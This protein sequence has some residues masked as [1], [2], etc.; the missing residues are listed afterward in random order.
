MHFP[1]CLS[2]LVHGYVSMQLN[3]VVVVVVVTDPSLGKCA[4]THT[5]KISASD[6]RGSP[7]Y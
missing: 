5:E 7:I 4:H 2:T 6:C 3:F 1:D